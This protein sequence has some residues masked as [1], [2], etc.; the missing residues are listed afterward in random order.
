MNHGWTW[1]DPDTPVPCS[2][3]STACSHKEQ[4]YSQGRMWYPVEN[5]WS[6][7]ESPFKTFVLNLPLVNVFQNDYI[8]KILF[9]YTWRRSFCSHDTHLSSEDSLS[10]MV[11]VFWNMEEK[12][13][14]F[15][16]H[17]FCWSYSHQFQAWGQCNYFFCLWLT[18]RAFR[19]SFQ[20]EDELKPWRQRLTQKNRRKGFVWESFLPTLSF[21][22]F[23]QNVEVNGAA[24]WIGEMGREQFSSRKFKESHP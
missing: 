14:Y 11:K 6:S 21:P 2:F 7:P 13:L 3:Q 17:C 12:S 23:F 18:S 9:P 15:F 16:S 1:L 22:L 5:E 10:I 24:S 20:C 19:F 8:L 4:A